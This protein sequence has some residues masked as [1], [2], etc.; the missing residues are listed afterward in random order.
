MAVAV[1]APMV[2]IVVVVV[3]IDVTFVSYRYENCLVSRLYIA[4]LHV[5]KR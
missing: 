5:E 1:A 3:I 2:V 4:L